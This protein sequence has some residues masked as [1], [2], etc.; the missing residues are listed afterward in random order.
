MPAKF[1]QVVG[2]GWFVARRAQA[3]QFLAGCGLKSMMIA[4][5]IWPSM[6]MA[7]REQ[8]VELPVPEGHLSGTL[9]L[10]DVIARQGCPVAL[11]IAGSGPTDR[12][13]NS[14]LEKHHIGNYRQLAEALASQGIASLR[15][16]KR[17]VGESH[18]VVTS[19]S[20]L[21]FDD[22]VD[23][24]LR[25]GKKLREDTRFSSVIFIGHSEGSLIGIMAGRRLPA[26]AVVSL[27]GVG[28]PA[29]KVLEKQLEAQL[30]PDMYEQ[31][32]SIVES[33]EQGREVK[34]VPPELGMVFRPSVQPYDISWFK[35]DPSQEIG[36]LVMPILIVQG[37]AD[38]QV[39]VEN[40]RQLE[41]ANSH[42][43]ML[44]L[45][46]MGHQLIDVETPAV[47]AGANHDPAMT[48]DSHLVLGVTAFIKEVTLNK[49]NRP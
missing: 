1:Q 44:M 25:W 11:I 14:R 37:E 30:P 26:D 12:D 23:D 17:G 4:I 45:P 6:T 27:E 34:D 31:A 18:G 21:R 8:L 9:T 46:N 24:A 39:G 47:D 28:G 36:R 16:D 29:S 5:A 22:F 43:R 49:E 35:L 3:K 13:G 10:P 7:A 19:E 2:A 32:K 41:S 48:I 20:R 38:G 15:Y 40:A 33:L 42:A